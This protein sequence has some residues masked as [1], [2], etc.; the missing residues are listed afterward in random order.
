MPQRSLGTAGAGF[1]GSHL[2]DRLLENGH[3]VICSNNVLTGDVQNIEHLTN[4]P[5]FAFVRH[6]VI[7]VAD[8]SILVNQMDGWSGH[9]V[10]AIPQL[11]FIFHLASPASTMHNIRCQ[12]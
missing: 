12:P 6:D 8:P 5:R 10:R 7:V 4:H 1:V 11:N 9:E 3:Q 2:C